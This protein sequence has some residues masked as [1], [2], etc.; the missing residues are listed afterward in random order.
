MNINSWLI[1]A[2]CLTNIVLLTARSMRVAL[3]VRKDSKMHNLDTD[4]YSRATPHTSPPVVPVYVFAII[5]MICTSVLALCIGLLAHSLFVDAGV[6]A[7]DTRLSSGSVL[8]L[9]GALLTPFPNFALGLRFR[10]GTALDTTE[11]AT[12]D[13][14]PWRQTFP[15]SIL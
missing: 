15:E 5:S 14:L 1:S 7:V 11:Q 9:M 6:N 8:G 4:L 2:S 10:C 13:P 3:R 12:P